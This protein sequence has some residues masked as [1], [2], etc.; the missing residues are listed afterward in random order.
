[1]A[2][3]VRWYSLEIKNN[4]LNIELETIC[5]IDGLWC[6]KNRKHLFCTSASA[7]KGYGESHGGEKD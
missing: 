4:H 2:D 3:R 7:L 5:K 6:W 1:M